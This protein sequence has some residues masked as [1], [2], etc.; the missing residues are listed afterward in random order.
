MNEKN[1]SK[2]FKVI[3]VGDTNVGKTSIIRR[4]TKGQ[5]CNINLTTVANSFS[6]KIININDQNINLQIWDTA[7]QERYRAISEIFFRNT[8]AIIFVYDITSK[9]SFDEISNFWYNYVIKDQTSDV[10]SALAANKA[11]LFDK[12]EVNEDEGRNFAEEKNLIFY[13]TSAKNGTR[14]DNLFKDIA[15]T[16]C[17]RK[18]LKK[19]ENNGTKLNAKNTE[20]NKNKKCC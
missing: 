16:L 13:L 18:V 7:G 3:L 8:D 1:I 10:I 20:K 14:I 15:T 6:N 2:T 19:K 11:D 17:E 9:K 5:F 12:E 4:Y